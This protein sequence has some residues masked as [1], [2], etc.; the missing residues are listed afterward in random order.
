MDLR[1]VVSKLDIVDVI[2]SYIDLKRVGSNYAGRCPFHPDDTPSLY[3]SPSKGIWKCFG[4]G[5]GGDAVKFVAL[6]EGVSYTEALMELARKYKI[7][8][9]LPSQRHDDALLEALRQASQ[10]YHE[11]LKENQQALEYLYG[12]GLSGRSIQRFELG[13]SPTSHQLC[14]FLK[15]AG[16][17]EVYERSGNIL[18]LADGSCR[19]MFAGRL[20]IPIR[21]HRGNVVAFG[22][23][24]LTDEKPKYL[25]S[26]EK[27]HFQKRNI[28][29]GFYEGKEFIKERRRVILVEGYF[30]VISMHQA[31]FKETVAPLGT[32]LTSQQAHLIASYADE[33][34]LIFD[35][36]S[37]GRQA[38]RRAVP[39]LLSENLSVKVLYL[40]E[41]EDPD[42]Y[43]K[44]TDLHREL[45]SLPD[46][47]EDLLSK[48]KNDRN[49]LETLLYLSGF[50]RDPV[51]RGEILLT[52]AKLTGMPVSLLSEKVP[53]VRGERE[54]EEKKL[55]F[56]EK[57]LLT[58]IL[59]YN[60]TNVPLEELNL[61]PYAAQILEAIQKEDLHLVPA[62]I[63]RG[64]ISDE[65]VFWD[66]VK[67]L[68][69]KKE[70]LEEETP[71][72]LSQLR[73]R[74][75]TR[76]RKRRL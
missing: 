54:E 28:L 41:G 64:R 40:P 61:S 55:T 22:G 35:G 45:E 73:K 14:Q 44:K 34:I 66:A 67:A 60:F 24:T 27:E 38:V 39:H 10:F 15:E 69:I 59:R 16:L 70:D 62:E 13:Y 51:K 48:A 6:Y 31:G 33:V 50:V 42:T 46:I 36:D 9:K 75:A 12:R 57:I 23:R 5:V 76:L 74:P 71:K 65:R 19:D 49:S 18:R 4:C 56:H 11:R 3:V 1:S 7:P 63:R 30:D 72:D 53:R 58:G 21:D 2:S 43:V 32:S 25:N 29:F 20:I 47:L 17:L 68:S 26:P 52:L 8:L 37:A